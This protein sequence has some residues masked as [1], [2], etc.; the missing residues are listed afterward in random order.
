MVTEIFC[1]GFEQDSRLIRNQRRQRVFAVPW[2]FEDIAAINLPSL[3]VTGFAGHTEIVFGAVVERLEIGIRH[4][5]VGDRG[6]LGN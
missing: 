4:R 1:A 5:P 3:Q 6:V 2:R